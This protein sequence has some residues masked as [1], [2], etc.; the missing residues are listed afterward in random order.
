MGPAGSGAVRPNAEPY[1]GHEGSAHAA[2]EA[3]P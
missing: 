1:Q 2:G 3:V